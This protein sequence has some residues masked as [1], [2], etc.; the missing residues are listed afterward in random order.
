MVGMLLDIRYIKRTLH[1][2]TLTI[3]FTHFQVMRS[4]DKYITITLKR[5]EGPDF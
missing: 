2:R 5:L 1:V 3:L 4:L